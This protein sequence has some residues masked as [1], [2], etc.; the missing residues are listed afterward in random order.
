MR[1]IGENMKKDDCTSTVENPLYVQSSMYHIEKYGQKVSGTIT[2][3][4]APRDGHSCVD[5]SQILD[6]LEAAKR[7]ANGEESQ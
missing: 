4:I 1:K 7:A 5:E 3:V 2:I 6:R